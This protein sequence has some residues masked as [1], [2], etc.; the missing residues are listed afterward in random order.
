MRRRARAGF[1]LAAVAA[2]G[3]GARWAYRE[4]RAAAM[5]EA[6]RA[7]MARG[8]FASACADFAGMLA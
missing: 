8:D 7:A 3:W 1:I 2:V 6:G 5:L 4:W